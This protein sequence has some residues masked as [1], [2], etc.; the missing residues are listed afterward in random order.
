MEV[1]KEGLRNKRKGEIM[2]DS[3]WIEWETN[4]NLTEGKGS[5]LQWETELFSQ[6]FDKQLIKENKVRFYLM[7]DVKINSR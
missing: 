3:R 5:L 2:C 7:P 1:E 4:G 6:W